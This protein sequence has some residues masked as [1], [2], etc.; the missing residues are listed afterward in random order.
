MGHC[1]ASFLLLS[2]L[3]LSGTS[4][5]HTVTFGFC[6]A[7]PNV[8]CM[9]IERKALLKLREGLS[10]PSDRLSSWGGVDCCN[11]RGIGCNKTTGRVESL[12]LRNPYAEG[13]DSDG[14][15]GTLHALGGVFYFQTVQ[16][17]FCYADPNVGCMNEER[18]ALLEL[19][20]NLTDPMDRLS[21]WMGEDC[22]KWRGV[23]CNKKTGRV[24]SLNLRN[25]FSD[26]LDVDDGALHALG[27][28]ISPSLLVLKDLIYLDLSMNNFE[29]LQLPSFI[30][31]VEKLTYLNLSGASFGGIIPANLGN[32]SNLLHLDLSN[33][34]IESDLRWLSSL[35]SLQFL[36]LG[37]A[38]LVKAAPY[39]LPTVNMLPSLLELHLRGC[40]LSILPPALPH[41][42]FTS[43]S[44]LDLSANGFNSTLS[45][46]LFSL[47]KLVS[48]DLSSN[49]LN[50][51][52]PE[53]LGSLTHLKNLDL[54]E[55][56]NI[57]GQLPRN[58]GMLCNLQ[59]LELSIN[60]VT[61]EIT[62]FID[63]LSRCTNSSL[64]RLDL[65]F[66]SLT[67]N[68]P[69]SL[70]LLKN[71][72]YLTLWDNSFQGSIPESV[73]NLTSLE[74][75]Y[76]AKNNLGGV[77]PESFGQLSSLV[78]VDLSENT[79]EGVVTEAHFL[80]LRS[81]KEVSIQKASPN[82]SLVF[83]IS[84]NWIPPF[85]LRY[86]YLRS[87]QVGPKFPT[88][89]RN[90]TELATVV[91]NNARIADT[92]PDWFWKL[93]LLLDE[94][95][96][97][98]NQLS[99]KVPNSLRFSF[100]AN[101]ALS[102]NLFDG[103]LPLWSS[104]IT[105]LYLRDNQFSGPIPYNIGVVMPFL[106]DLDISLNDLSG[107]IPL[108]LGNLSVL[109]T[110]VISNN[111]L[112]GE[113]PHFWKS[114]PDLYIVDM[115][116][117]SLSGTIPRS[118]DSL[119][120]L[121]YLIL[122]NNNLSGKLPSLRNC[123]GMKSLDLGENKFFGNIPAWIGESM[124]SLLILRL[125]SNS[126]TGNIPLQ[127]C[128]LSNLHILDL[129][130]N[131]LSGH[132]PHCVGNLSGLKISE[133]SDKDTSYLYQGK[134]KVVTKGRVLA[135]YSTLYLVNSLD[136]SNNNLSGEMPMEL[137]TLVKLWTLNLSMNHLTGTI[138]PKI[139]NMELIETL[140]LS[141]NKL[142]GSIPPSMVSMTFLTH[143][144]LSY[145]NLSGKIPTAN[146]F[147]TLVDPSVYEGNDAL[148]G[149]PLLTG[150]Q[151]DE[152]P[153]LPSEDG[154]ED[155]SK[156]WLIIS[157]VIGFITG[158]WGVFGSL[159]IKKSWRYAY[160]QFLDKIKYALLDFLSSMG[161]RLRKGADEI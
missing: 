109:T 115:S 116:N 99:G 35:S 61:G 161:N 134:L 75:F 29:S 18:R 74:E 9:D 90:Q 84:S 37:G 82:I 16:H 120:S 100:P 118:M 53:T 17:G 4:Y 132:I 81:L 12:D 6:N 157:V 20:Q 133:I 144:N 3:L 22:C 91:L 85:K 43:L 124:L 33:N 113:I 38:D 59:S 93:D 153:Q 106:S 110:M 25:P 41:I 57:G 1:S 97:A 77:I 36:N 155:D 27:G 122:S 26:G 64:E 31:S 98:Y 11:W 108:S 126:F 78:A 76:L 80:K 30:G 92:F 138:P 23:G 107:R 79:W 24:I 7:D 101:A 123:T 147:K 58:L 48:L 135:Y 40:G 131:E 129:S 151:G 143:L 160:F 69:N 15:D 28:E 42:N 112:T 47:T 55:N 5:L 73:G 2:L 62:D 146:Q 152:S 95:N 105:T 89:L 52:L 71:L 13:L 65:G 70:G 150:C 63:S 154:E 68:L 159:V 125:S 34:V 111:Y 139:G 149:Y 142:S 127:L 67:G 87:C 39:W 137:T 56:S 8:G 114:I 145:N 141:I 19:K 128:G 119:I 104:N 148:C 102:S 158:F 21:S 46:W 10:D 140:D 96:M 130:H 103:P 66:N 88:W 156:L 72:R 51:E 14:D 45:P 50:G 32:L 44:V 49:N 60:K 86:L 94:L 117:N 83:N 54:S 136:L 121:R